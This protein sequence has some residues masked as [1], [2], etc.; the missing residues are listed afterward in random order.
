MS[1][2]KK[3]RTI[4]ESVYFEYEKGSGTIT[5]TE[6]LNTIFKCLDGSNNIINYNIDNSNNPIKCERIDLSGDITIN[7]SGLNWNDIS[8][9]YTILLSGEIIFDGKDNTVFLKDCSG[10]QGLIISD[11]NSSNNRPTISNIDISGSGNTHLSKYNDSYGTSYLMRYGSLYFNLENCHN[12][13][14]IKNADYCGGLVPSYI[15]KTPHSFINITKCSN[16][17]KITNSEAAGGICGYGAGIKGNCTITNSYNIGNIINSRFS[18]GICGGSAGAYNG[19]CTI[20]NSYNTGDINNSD[21]AG[22]ICGIYAG[23]E[24]NCTINNSYNTGSISH[25]E[26]SGGF[27]VNILV[28]KVILTLVIVSHTLIH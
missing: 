16:H 15:S 2:P 8:K 7:G 9:P 26:N 20:T 18:G 4:I 12:Y 27:V 13:I 23:D 28:I 14:E 6:A 22:G 3:L 19:N 21:G 1:K 24:G 17:G 25:S 5:I 11:S 10:W